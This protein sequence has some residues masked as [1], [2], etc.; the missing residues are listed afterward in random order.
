MPIYLDHNATSPPRPE[1]LAAALPL[2]TEGWANP[3]STHAMARRPAAAVEGA[4][5]QVAGWAAARPKDVIFT[6]GAT[7]ADHLA[8]RG[9]APPGGRILVS[10]IEHPAVLAPALA[11]G[12]E[13]I[14]VTPDGVVDLSL[15]HI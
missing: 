11:R 10:A 15:I 9:A 4:R 3:A 12:A 14:P 1:A 8:I 2:L 7:E 13:R 5:R 6:S